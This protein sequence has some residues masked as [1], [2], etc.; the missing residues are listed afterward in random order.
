[1][2][3]LDTNVVSELMSGT[4]TPTVVEWFA[5]QDP[6]SLHLTTFTLAEI[7]YGIAVLPRGR[8]KAA[9][10]EGFEERILPA[11][12]GRIL[13]FDELAA[14]SYAPALARARKAGRAIGATDGY[15]AAIALA[16]GCAVATRDR[17]PFDSA[18]V[19]V[20]DPF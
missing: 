13:A 4:P 11:F 1:M 9:L 7:R 18:G 10:H 14:E 15:I 3:I 5:E 6:E 17:S 8:R 12:D 19:T 20:I 16:H 2:I